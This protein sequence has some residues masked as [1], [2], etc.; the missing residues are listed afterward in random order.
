MKLY[1]EA[2]DLSDIYIGEDVF[3]KI[4]DG[5]KE[6]NVVIKADVNGSVEAVKSALE[7][8]TV[9]GSAEIMR[10]VAK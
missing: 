5:V 4:Q 3:A 6:I 2:S 1:F 8:I 10:I 9:E 7:K